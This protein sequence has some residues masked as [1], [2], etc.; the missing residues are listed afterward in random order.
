ML[1]GL[2]GDK[3]QRLINLSRRNKTHMWLENPQSGDKLIVAALLLS[4][5][6]RIMGFLF[7]SG[8]T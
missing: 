4:I 3:T 7:V 2:T 5:V 6:I 1:Y 8:G